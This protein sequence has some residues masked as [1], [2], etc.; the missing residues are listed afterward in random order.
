MVILSGCTYSVSIPRVG[1]TPSR[2]STGTMS[3]SFDDSSHGD[4]LVGTMC[5]AIG[6]DCGD[7]QSMR[8]RGQET[9]AEWRLRKK[10]IILLVYFV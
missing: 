3:A 2:K 6:E 5:F 10:R 9:L 7:L 4:P 1:R 8:R